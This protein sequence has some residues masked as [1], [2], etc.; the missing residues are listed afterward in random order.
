MGPTLVGRSAELATLTAAA[1]AVAAG[2]GSVVHLVGEAGI[3]KTTL[4]NA[5]RSELDRRDIGV[6]SGTADETDRRRPLVLARAL[7]P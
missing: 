7:V 1:D 5:A 3:G 4:L 6:R 2:T